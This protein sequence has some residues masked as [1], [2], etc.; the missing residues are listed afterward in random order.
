MGPREIDSAPITPC[1]LCK[2]WNLLSLELLYD[3]SQ[4]DVMSNI[5]IENNDSD[6]LSSVT[7]FLNHLVE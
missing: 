1:H 6:F 4:T 3:L 2:L 7:N 5:E